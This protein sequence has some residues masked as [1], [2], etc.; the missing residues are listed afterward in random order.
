MFAALVVL[1]LSTTFN[2]PA[3]AGDYL[4]VGKF[5]SGQYAAKIRSS[6]SYLLGAVHAPLLLTFQF[7]VFKVTNLI[8]L[9]LL[10]WSVFV[11]SGKD[12]RTLWLFLVAPAVWYMAPWIGPIQVAALAMLW[13]WFFMERYAKTGGVKEVLYAGLL[14]GLGWAFWD[15]ILFFGAFLGLVYL[16]HRKL[17][18]GFAFL[19]LVAVGLLPRLILDA[20]LFGFPIYTILKSSMGTLANIGGGIYGGQGHTPM[21][22]FD[23]IWIFLVVPFSFWMLYTK[24]LFVKHR[25]SMIWL[26]LCLVLILANPQMRYVLVL[27]P[28]MIILSGKYLSKEVWKKIMIASVL[29]SALLVS[30]YVV[31]VN[32]TFDSSLQTH[33]LIGYDLKNVVQAYRADGRLEVTDVLLRNRVIADVQQLA[34]DYPDEAFLVGPDPDSYQVLADLYWG[35]RV[36][37][38]V[39]VQDYDLSKT[40]EVS[41]YERRWEPV[42]KIQS[43][44]QI[45][46]GGGLNKN[47]IDETDY[48]SI[49]YAVGYIKDFAPKG[50]VEIEKYDTLTVF[51]KQ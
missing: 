2:G 19:A 1:A 49:E 45:W 3:D 41:L 22:L 38:F 17:G 27:A 14:V 5:L 16:W 24:K 12:R 15:T 30:P 29:V 50:F 8:L 26:S 34:E 33:N 4:D 32:G 13:A 25:K 47:P 20:A 46:V 51:Q 42:P 18:H 39:S 36:K 7:G 11:V 48:D 37:E 44:R 35:S 6:H 31:Q 43:R 28:V 40:D 21:T 9:A 10:V 23:L